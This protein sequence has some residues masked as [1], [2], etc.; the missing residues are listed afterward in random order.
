MEKYQDQKLSLK[1]LLLFRNNGV[2]PNLLQ[3]KHKII[4]S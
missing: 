2:D 3:F 1:A 4:D